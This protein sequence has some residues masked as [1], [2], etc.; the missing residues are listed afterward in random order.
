MKRLRQI[1][2]C[3]IVGPAELDA[4][5]SRREEYFRNMEEIQG[6]HRISPL[7]VRTLWRLGKKSEIVEY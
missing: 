3:L 7:A 6:L 2:G 1:N 4:W 5:M